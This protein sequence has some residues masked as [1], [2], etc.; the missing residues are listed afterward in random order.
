MT[1][2]RRFTDERA[3]LDD[4]MDE[5]LV[6]CPECS[7]CARTFRV[8]RGSADSFAPRRLVCACG[9]TR[10]WAGRV[11]GMPRGEPPRDDYFHLPLWL[12]ARCAGET[13]WAY[14]REHLAF[15][16]SFVGA[17][18]R[19]RLRDAKHGWR[20]ASLVSRLPKWMKLAK[21]R[22]AILRAIARLEE[23]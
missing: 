17:T 15:L 3:T 2:P 23:K 4:F 16:R 18:Q 21:H 7:G 14:N 9:H 19:E 5:I 10:E 20:N 12:R 11:L 6:V 13:L 1:A 8:E 22:A